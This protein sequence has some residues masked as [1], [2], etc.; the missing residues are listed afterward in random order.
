MTSGTRMKL[1][2]QN[3]YIMYSL[4]LKGFES[5]VGH[6]WV[7][8]RITLQFLEGQDANLK[9]TTSTLIHTEYAYVNK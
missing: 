4:Q 6:M 8:V 2:F 3:T 5:C 9:D 7:Q 1:L